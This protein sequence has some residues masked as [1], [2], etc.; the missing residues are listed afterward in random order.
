M[1]ILRYSGFSIFHWILQQMFQLPSD[2]TWTGVPVV[3][4]SH[5]LKTP[6]Y[7]TCQLMTDGSSDFSWLLT[8][9]T[10][11]MFVLLMLSLLWDATSCCCCSV[12]MK[13]RSPSSL[14]PFTVATLHGILVQ[15]IFRLRWP[16]NH[17]CL[18][19]VWILVFS[20][21]KDLLSPANS[22][23]LVKEMFP[24]LTF[25]SFLANVNSHSRSLYAVARPYICCLSSVCR[26]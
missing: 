1:C 5:H 22:V 8:L 6:F 4:C 12:Q 19:L 21:I 18:K 13:Q 17:G 2:I 9:Y 23:F 11:Q 7:I 14:V 15:W 10:L 26:L 3:F 24:V 16:M 20:L 25:A